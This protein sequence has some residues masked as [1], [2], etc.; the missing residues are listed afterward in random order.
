MCRE[1]QL[2]NVFDINTYSVVNIF[3]ITIRVSFLFQ[4]SHHIL[5]PSSFA[6]QSF[7]AMHLSDSQTFQRRSHW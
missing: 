5:I 4:S 1:E 7:A 3:D 2:I 6:C